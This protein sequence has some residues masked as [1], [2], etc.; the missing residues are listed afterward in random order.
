MANEIEKRNEAILIY[1]DE[2]RIAL[3]LTTTPGLV[4]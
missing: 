3:A 2:N 1:Q 4:L